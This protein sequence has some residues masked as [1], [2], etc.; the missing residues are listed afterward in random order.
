MDSVRCLSDSFCGQFHY[1]PPTAR[2]GISFALIGLP[3][4]FNLKAA[5]QIGL[6]LSLE[7]LSRANKVIK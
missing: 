3:I 6:T 1:G 5:K 7:F 2:L 4:L